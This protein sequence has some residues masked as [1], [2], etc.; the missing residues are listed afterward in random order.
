MTTPSSAF[1]T[2]STTQSGKNEWNSATVDGQWNFGGA[3]IF[4]S[5]YFN[6]INSNAPYQATQI[7][8][9]Q[10]NANLGYISAYGFT[11]QPAMYID[12]KVEIFSRYEYSCWSSTQTLV[13]QDP[14]NIVTVGLNWYLDGQ[15]LKWTTDCGMNVGSDVGPSYIDT[16]SGWRASGQGEF[17][18]RTR[19][20]LIF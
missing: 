19:L 4:A 2:S 14:L 12:P 9:P 17:V 1:D 8:R 11:F 5:G 13:Q 7:T 6:Y 18:F 16:A 10:Q 20:Q 3:S 15:D